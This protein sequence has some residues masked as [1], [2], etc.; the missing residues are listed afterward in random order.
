[1][2]G[3]HK[4]K[5]PPLVCFLKCAL[6]VLNCIYLT[7]YLSI[8]LSICLE[9]VCVC[10]CVCVCLCKD[11]LFIG[12]VFH[13]TFQLSQNILQNFLLKV[14]LMLWLE[15]KADQNWL[16]LLNLVLPNLWIACWLGISMYVCIDFVTNKNNKLKQKVE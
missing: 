7:I 10:V 12:L 2:F 4:F 16:I 8:Y 14:S 6:Y 15:F 3:V 9:C 13:I 1:M 5:C 11:I